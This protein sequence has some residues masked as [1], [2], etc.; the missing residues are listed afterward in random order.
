M[1]LFKASGKFTRADDR[2][3][4][5]FTPFRVTGLLSTTVDENDETE[6]RGLIDCRHLHA[7]QIG[8]QSMSQFGHGNYTVKLHIWPNA[9]LTGLLQDNTLPTTGMLACKYVMP[10][11]ARYAALHHLKTLEKN[12]ADHAENSSHFSGEAHPLLAADIDSETP[13]AL[14]VGANPDAR[15]S[16][17]K[18]A[19]VIRFA[20]NSNNSVY[21]QGAFTADLDQDGDF[22]TS[23]EWKEYTLLTDDSDHFGILPRYEASVNPTIDEDFNTV[24]N[25][26]WDMPLSRY[27]VFTETTQFQPVT[28]NLSRSSEIGD[29]IAAA[30]ITSAT[31]SGIEAM[32]GLIEVSC[33]SLLQLG[34]FQLNNNDFDIYATVTCHS[35]T[36]MKR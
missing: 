35:W 34:D 11:K 16:G 7:L 32:G 27:K 18:G 23:H 1:P 28:Y 9:G 31:F 3:D 19:K 4:G 13:N 29:D 30:S 8:R 25:I 15:N 21:G 6:W 5:P 20:Y 26:E 24:V 17:N 2:N 12:N 33:P 22:G 10:T 36:P 14:G